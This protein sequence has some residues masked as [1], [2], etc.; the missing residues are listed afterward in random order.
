MEKE[1]Q[2]TMYPKQ[3]K[4]NGGWKILDLGYSSRLLEHKMHGRGEIYFDT[5]IYVCV[6]LHAVRTVCIRSI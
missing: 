4:S 2:S 5:C 6:V 1:N 3:N